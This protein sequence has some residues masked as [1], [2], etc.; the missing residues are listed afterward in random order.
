[1]Y[2][3]PAMIMRATQKKMMSGAGHEIG[4][5]I[6]LRQ[7]VVRPAHR[8]ERP[9]PGAETRCRARRGPAPSSPHRPAARCRHEWLRR[10]SASLPI[11]HRNAMPPPELAADA[12]VLDVLQPVVVNLRPALGMKTASRR[13][14][15]HRARFLHAR[16]LQEPLLAQARLDRHIGALAEADVVLVRLFLRQQ[17]RAPSSISAAFLRASKRSSPSRSGPRGRSSCRPDAGRR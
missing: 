13:S 8:G 12:P 5:R 9:E 3:K 2:S 7:R 10:T 17:R 16:I 6:E 1:M 15:T 11:P 4:R 14:A